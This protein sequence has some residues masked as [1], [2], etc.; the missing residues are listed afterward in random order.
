MYVVSACLAGIACRY[1]ATPCPVPEVLDLVA[2]GLALPV[3]PEVLGGLPVP[4][5][6]CEILYGRV[7]DAEGTERTAAFLA[8]V[9]EAM[10][11]TREFGATDAILKARSPSCGAGRIYDGTFTGRL[12]PGDGFWARALRA[13]GIRIRT[14]EDVCRA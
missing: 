9:D 10:R 4:R 7:V 1:N 5:P 3:C 6:P 8:G 13:E 11:R 14:E 2:R 12:V